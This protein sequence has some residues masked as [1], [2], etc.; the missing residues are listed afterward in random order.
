MVVMCWPVMSEVLYVH[1]FLKG[2]LKLFLP[3]TGSLY[4]FLFTKAAPTTLG[5]SIRSARQPVSSD[6]LV[7]SPSP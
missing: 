5:A 1:P 3:A 7:H 2:T 6:R 4:R